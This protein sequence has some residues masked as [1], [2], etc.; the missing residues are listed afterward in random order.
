MSERHTHRVSELLRN[1][2]EDTEERIPTKVKKWFDDLVGAFHYGSW[3]N[4]QAYYP[5]HYHTSHPEA[6]YSADVSEGLT[7]GNNLDVP[8]GESF[9]IPTWHSIH[10]FGS[11]VVMSSYQ[12]PL[13]I[14]L[15]TFGKRWHSENAHADDMRDFFDMF[16]QVQFYVSIY[17]IKIISC[18][19]TQMICFM[20]VVRENW[21]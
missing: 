2:T 5:A 21:E 13:H 6:R 3:C 16:G 11:I 1:H 4:P 9:Q 12:E 7:G 19:L 10:E 14:P 18:F 17:F 20:Q 8:H 15:T